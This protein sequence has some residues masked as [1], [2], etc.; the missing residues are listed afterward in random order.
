[1]EAEYQSTKS[2]DTSDEI[3]IEHFEFA[4][5]IRGINPELARFPFCMVWTPIPLLTWLI[6]LIGHVG[7]ATSKG[8]I[9]DFG[10]SYF[11]S[12]DDFSFGHTHKYC[13]L[14]IPDNKE[15]E[16]DKAI[17]EADDCYRGQEHN[18]CWYFV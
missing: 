11:I 7:I 2:K 6:P 17:I 14:D 13:K 8:I 1:M 3:Q 15:N 5:P 10:G 12:I 9:H 18:L 16:Y 4:K